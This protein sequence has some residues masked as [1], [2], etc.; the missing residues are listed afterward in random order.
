MKSTRERILLT[1]LERSRASIAELAEEAGINTIS[2]RHHL[3]ALQSEGMVNAEE[4]R[5]GVG[6]PRLVY[7]LTEKG[8]EH[9]P[10]RYY[11]LTNQL[12]EQ[13][14][15]VLPVETIQQ[16]FAGL[17]N[18]ISSEQG[19][20]A[21]SRPIEEKLNILKE[22][23]AREGFIVEWDKGEDSYHLREISCP[24]MHIGHNHPEVCT[25]D[26]TI[27]ANIL[28]VP[29]QKIT[30]VLSGDNLCTYVIPCSSTETENDRTTH[31]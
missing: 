3:D 22:L 26:Q 21:F 4:E 12:I 1:L 13:M 20:R 19:K 7:F 15:Q 9:F 8:Q 2:V 14:K 10:T 17:A 25:L 6:R 16:I 24:Y 28:N 11:R 30:C 31:Q 5:H 27:I 29:A 18:D 23:L